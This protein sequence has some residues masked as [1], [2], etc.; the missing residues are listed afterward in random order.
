MHCHS[1]PGI[2]VTVGLVAIAAGASYPGRG[3][4]TSGNQLAP[5]TTPPEAPKAAET[6]IFAEW[7]AHGSG[8]RAKSNMAGDV[9]MERIAQ[10]AQSQDRYAVRFHLDQ[11]QLSS[12]G[13]APDAPRDFAKECAIRVQLMPP[14]GK[15]I[16][17]LRA[18]TSVLSIKSAGTKLTLAGTLKIGLQ[19]LNQRIV[20][21][22]V[23]SIQ[24]GYEA[25]DLAPGSRAE[26]AFPQLQCGEPKL[27][28]FDFTWIAERNVKTD[29][30]FVMVSDD[31]VLEMVVDLEDCP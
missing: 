29:D 16:K 14:A 24:A 17:G 31:K 26:Q 25:F 9:F 28:G 10:G 27:G 20:V 3:P 4:F 23:G 5:P 21:E 2:L 12:A 11:L 15:R 19:T 1:K 30:V 7:I 18:T 6:P 8:C 22:P 13:R